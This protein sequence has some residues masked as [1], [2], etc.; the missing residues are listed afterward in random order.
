MRAKHHLG[1]IEVDT[2]LENYIHNESLRENHDSTW[3]RRLGSW[4]QVEGFE[5]M[6]RLA[7][8]ESVQAVDPEDARSSAAA[9]PDHRTDVPAG[10]HIWGLPVSV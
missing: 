10:E 4:S 9:G 1:S 3:L 6:Y 5:R 7:K 8:L 2:L